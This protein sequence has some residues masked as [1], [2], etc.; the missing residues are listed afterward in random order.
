VVITGTFDGSYE[1][2]EDGVFE[3]LIDTRPLDEAFGQDVC[4][5]VGA[6]GAA[7]VTCADGA[8][9]CLEFRAENIEAPWIE[10]LDLKASSG[11]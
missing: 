4:D 2:I 6:F 11:C 8:E 10:G 3:G 9:K 1:T 7:C 5:L